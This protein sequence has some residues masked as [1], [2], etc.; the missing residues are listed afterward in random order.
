MNVKEIQQQNIRDL[1]EV[2][3][4]RLGKEFGSFLVESIVGKKGLAMIENE[5]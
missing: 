5:L 3:E 4:R 2:L 1:K